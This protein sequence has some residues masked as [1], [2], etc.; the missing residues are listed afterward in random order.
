MEERKSLASELVSLLLPARFIIVQFQS[1]SAL[2]FTQ[3]A[4]YVE[5]FDSSPKPAFKPHI[6]IHSNGVILSF[7]FFVL[8]IPHPP[9]EL[10]TL[11]SFS[12]SNNKNY[13]CI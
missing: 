4:S 13:M 10:L 2:F 12:V 5:S 6:C 8:S 3:Q 11:W 7:P 9:L 1:G